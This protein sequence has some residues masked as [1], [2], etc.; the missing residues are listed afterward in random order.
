M[1]ERSETSVTP[2]W[3]GHQAVIA[4]GI[5]EFDPPDETGNVPLKFRPHVPV[6]FDR[7][8]IIDRRRDMPKGCREWWWYGAMNPVG[9][10][11]LGFFES[12]ATGKALIGF[13]MR[14]ESLGVSK[15][16]IAEAGFERIGDDLYSRALADCRLELTAELTRISLRLARREVGSGQTLVSL[17]LEDRTPDDKLIP[18]FWPAGLGTIDRLTEMVLA[19]AATAARQT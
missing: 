4:D 13:G 1:R 11:R 18:I 6:G 12:Q 10:S 7:Q 14:S 5:L 3:V 15:I 8:D 2:Q 17:V 16:L 19:R 9:G